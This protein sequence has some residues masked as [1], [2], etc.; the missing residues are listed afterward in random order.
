MRVATCGFCA[1]AY[2]LVEVEAVL[3]LKSQCVYCCFNCQKLF[4]VRSGVCVACHE[5]GEV[6]NV[7]RVVAGHSDLLYV[8]PLNFGS[9]LNLL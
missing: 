6:L 3:D 9:Q 4:R 2:D 1:Q 5:T 8:A 7:L